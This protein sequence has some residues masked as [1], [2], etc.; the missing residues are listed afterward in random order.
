MGPTKI[1]K[2]AVGLFAWP[3]LL[4]WTGLAKI[5]DRLLGRKMNKYGLP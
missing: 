1:A 2:A 4:L 5:K 3:L